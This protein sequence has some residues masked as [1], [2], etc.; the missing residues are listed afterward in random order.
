MRFDP[1]RLSTG[2]VI[3]VTLVAAGWGLR[4]VEAPA[5]QVLRER[6]PGWQRGALE[7]ALGQGV[8]V[9]LLG[10]FRSLV[11]DLFWIRANVAWEGKDLPTTQTLI[12]V[13]T[14][15]DPRP[16]YFWLNGARI[17]AY[18][19][20]D[21]RIAQEGG[22]DVVP[23]MRQ[24]E[25]DEEQA[26]VAL[27]Y[28]DQARSFHPTESA[29]DIEVA[30]VQLNRRQDLAEAA[31]AYRAAASRPEAPAYAARIYGELLRRMGR[32]DEA[33]AW[34]CALYPT[35]PREPGP[36]VSALQVEAAM[37]TVVLGRIRELEAQLGVPPE[38]RFDPPA[39][40]R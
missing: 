35:L 17:I 38:R 34:L 32:A 16:I 11:A 13:V 4:G 20:P 1:R 12:K 25:I 19:M 33:Y 36:G 6:E 3:L 8:P 5:W 37:A 14:A 10:G 21:W 30:N 2:A 40:A 9:G 23:A 22:H 29:L 28:L 39:V 18:D 15:V 27:A 7:G 31:A 24:R 26:A